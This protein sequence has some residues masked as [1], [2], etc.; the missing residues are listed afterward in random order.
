MSGFT[1]ARWSGVWV[2]RDGRLGIIWRGPSPVYRVC[3]SAGLCDL[4]YTGPSETICLSVCLSVC[5][6]VP[7]TDRS[8]RVSEK[9][10]HAVQ[11]HLRICVDERIY[12]H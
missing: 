10:L 4:Q 2:P 1:F 11:S 8:W 5:H 9:T 3:H 6:L 7:P 12:D